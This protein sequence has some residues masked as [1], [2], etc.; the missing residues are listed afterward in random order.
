MNGTSKAERIDIRQGSAFRKNVAPGIVAVA[1]CNGIVS[2]F[3]DFQYIALQILNEIVV[4]PRPVTG[5][6]KGNAADTPASIHVV[7]QPKIH[8]AVS[9]VPRFSHDGAA[10]DVEN[11]VAAVSMGLPHPDALGIVRIGGGHAAVGDGG[12]LP[13]VLPGIHLGAE[14]GRV[15]FQKLHQ[16]D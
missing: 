11:V 9:P 15:N 5:I 6:P 16:E 10:Q 1:G 2:A 14:P 3:S 8:F 7:P 12:Q 4:R 13:T